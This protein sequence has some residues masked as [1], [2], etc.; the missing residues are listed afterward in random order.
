MEFAHVATPSALDSAPVSAMHIARVQ[1]SPNCIRLT[2][3]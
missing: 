2:V 1:A 3:C